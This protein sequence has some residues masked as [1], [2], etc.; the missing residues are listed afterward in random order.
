MKSAIT[1]FCSHLMQ[2]GHCSIQNPVF[3]VY[4]TGATDHFNLGGKDGPQASSSPSV[5][6]SDPSSGLQASFLVSL[7]E[8]D[9]PCLMK[10]KRV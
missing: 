4:G 9:L 5:S 7:H 10:T 2:R 6:Q 1:V 3:N 8:P